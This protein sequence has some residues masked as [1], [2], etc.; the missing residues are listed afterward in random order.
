MLDNSC[1]FFIINKCCCLND[2]FFRIVLKLIECCRLYSLKNLNNSFSC[3]SSFINKLSNQVI[4]LIDREITCMS[5]VCRDCRKVLHVVVFS[6][7]NLKVTNDIL[8]FFF[9]H[10]SITT[11]HWL[12]SCIILLVLCNFI[13]KEQ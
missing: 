8:I 9:E 11:I 7:A 1:C 5:F 2:E 10:L 3:K 6:H 13:N 12:T 4:F